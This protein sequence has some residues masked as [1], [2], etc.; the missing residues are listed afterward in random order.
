MRNWDYLLLDRRELDEL[1]RAAVL[2]RGFTVDFATLTLLVPFLVFL[3][4]TV[5]DAAVL[6]AFV[7]LFF[8]VVAL[9]ERLM[10]D[11]AFPLVV[12]FVVLLRLFELVARCA[13][14]ESED[15]R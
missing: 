8:R 6:L 14:L 9:D 3:R 7:V 2:V 5:F 4:T 1:R 10:D 12:D 13:A 15:M 11:F